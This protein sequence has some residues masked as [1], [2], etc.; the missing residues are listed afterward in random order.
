M[1]IAVFALN[2]S[3]VLTAYLPI[4]VNDILGWSIYYLIGSY[5]GIHWKESISP[6]RMYI[7][8]LI[9]FIGSCISFIFAFVNVQKWVDL[10]LQNV[11]CS[12]PV[13]FDLDD[14]VAKGKNVD[15][16]YVS[17]LCSSSDYGVVL[18]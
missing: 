15:E 14:S 2:F 8:V 4:K 17:Y 18:E 11:W 12:I 6:K 10:Y 9:F 1:V 7:P 16:K 3:S 13:V 5:L